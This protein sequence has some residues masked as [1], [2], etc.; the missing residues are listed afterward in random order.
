[1]N[2]QQEGVIK[3]QLE[4]TATPLRPEVN[5]ALLNA[6]RTICYGVKLIGQDPGRYEGYGFGNISQRASHPAGA[7]VISGTQTGHIPTLTA[8]H[9]TLVV[10]CQPAQNRVTAEGPIAPS[11]ESMTHAILYQL[12][13]HIQAIIHAHSPEMWQC[14]EPLDLPTTAADVPYGTPAMTQEVARLFAE[15]DVR[16]RGLF[17]MA[18]HEDG[19]VAFGSSLEEAGCRLLVTLA[20]ALEK[21]AEC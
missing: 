10:A 4:Y 19:I 15:S 16:Q 20:Q 9:Y 2:H 18:G 6:W 8:A 1:M 14:R 13:P 21:S 5:I 17:A 3:F 12:D 11:S 7:F